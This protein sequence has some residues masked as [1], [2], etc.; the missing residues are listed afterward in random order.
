[1][2]ANKHEAIR[3]SRQLWLALK[4]TFIVAGVI[5]GYWCGVEAV[6]VEAIAVARSRE[7]L[8]EPAGAIFFLIIIAGVGCAAVAKA[9]EWLGRL[10]AWLY[11]ADSGIG[12]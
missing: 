3:L 4:L 5:W 2:S 12:R 11:A 7:L 1:M 10:E 8:F 9:W 6:V